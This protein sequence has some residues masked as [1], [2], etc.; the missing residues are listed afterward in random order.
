MTSSTRRDTGYFGPA[1]ACALAGAAMFQFF[2]NATRGYIDTAS[3]F[4]WWSFQWVNPGSETEHGP[5]ILVISVWLLVRNLRASGEGREAR[6]ETSWPAL[7]AMAMGLALH[8]VGFAGQQGRISIVALLVF[9]WGVLRL[10]GGRRWGAAAVFPLGFLVFA[11]PLNVLDSVGFW[12]R[13]GVIKASAGIAH[14]AGIGVL[15]SGTQLLAPDG[16]YNYDVAAACSGVRSLMA[17]AAL[18]LLVG[19]LNFRAWWRRGALLLLCFPLVYLGNV[20]RV[21]AIVFAAQWAGPA[22]G[23]RVHEWFGFVV[24]LIVL[25]GVLVVAEALRRLWPEGVAEDGE[26]KKEVSRLDEVGCGRWWRRSSPSRLG[27]CFFCSTSHHC[28]RAARRA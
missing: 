4:Y 28:L 6:G 14:A 27:R 2:G 9:A 18:S 17:L 24:F 3:L 8:A 10:G 7:A 21:A 16:R 1:L 15:Q 25:G 20:A 22:W 13:L 11:I 26:R 5:I 23:E 19:Y 12:L